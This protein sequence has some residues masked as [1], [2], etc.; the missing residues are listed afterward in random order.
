MKSENG[1]TAVGGVLAH[2]M[3]GGLEPPDWPPLEVAEVGALLVDYGLSGDEPR[4][5]SYSPRPFSAAGV[6]EFGGRRLFVK[7]HHR[8][9]RDAAGLGEEHGFLD[10]LAGRGAAVPR[11]LRTTTGASAV[12]RGNWCYEVH[13]VAEGLDL[14]GEAL[15]WTPFRTVAHAR[16]AGAALGRLHRTAE[17]YG[18]P[19][20]PPRPLVASFSLWRVD[21]RAAALEAFLD[22]RPAL[23]ADQVTRS[24][25]RRALALLEPWGAALHA[26]VPELA[27][28]WT[29]ND[30]HPSNLLW[31]DAGPTAQAVAVIDF[32]LA[33]RTTA[34][35]DLALA[36]ER[37]LVGW[38]KLDFA[39]GEEDRVPVQLDQLAALLE[40]YEQA[41]PLS[42]A[43]R[44]ALAPALALC[45]FEYALSEADYFLSALGSAAKARLASVDYL[46]GHARWLAGPGREKLLA[47]LERWAKGGSVAR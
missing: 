1:R 33:D 26:L 11:V 5:L 15:S 12:E 43:E 29:H 17:G 2:G 42:A 14:Y 13:S 35:H 45:H 20:R 6:V 32:G 23:A 27:P 40:G 10:Y 46:L 18:A 39:C 37:S 24:S 19:A 22:A 34:V 21:D 7:R 47:P 44:A 4:I 3:N 16:S 41:R 38:L 9:V 28:L 8:A 36:I 30:L 25:A 31:S